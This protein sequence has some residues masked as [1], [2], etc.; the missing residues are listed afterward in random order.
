MVFD[1][2]VLGFCLRGFSDN[3]IESCVY[4]ILKVCGFY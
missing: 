4:D 3:D 1:E 2:V